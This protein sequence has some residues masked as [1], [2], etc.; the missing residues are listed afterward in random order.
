MNL[1]ARIET[2]KTLDL[3][4]KLTSD[5]VLEQESLSLSRAPHSGASKLI[6]SVHTNVEVV[7]GQRV[8]A[9]GSEVNSN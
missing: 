9:R 6:F 1:G 4:L 2:K 5:F 7:Q 8:M 3:G